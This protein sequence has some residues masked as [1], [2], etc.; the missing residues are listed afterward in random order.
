M[1]GKTPHQMKENMAGQISLRGKNLI[2]KGS[3]LD[4]EFSR[5]E[6]S[7][8]FNLVDVGAVFFAGP[9]GLLATKGFNIANVFRGSGGSSQI[10][11]LV[12]DWQVEH[13]IAKAQDVAMATNEN[14]LAL[15]GEVNLVTE[16]FNEMNVALIDVHG[17]AK[18]RQQIHGSFQEP[19]VEAP[20]VFK[21]LSGPMVNLFNKGMA[22]VSIGDCE[23]FYA[24]SVAP[25]K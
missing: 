24:G 20:N 16:Q 7:Q 11:T 4:L 22:L 15:R 12:S 17:C 10:Q 2:I 8:N 25:P 9:V 1:Q 13:G 23:V 21:S 18:I 14:R 6:S 5:F 3:D 19:K